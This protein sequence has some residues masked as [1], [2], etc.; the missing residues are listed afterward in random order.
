MTNPS[1]SP[2]K[3]DDLLA[4][5]TDRVLDEKD[6]GFASSTNNELRA[7]E[8]TVLRLQRTLP[9]KSLDKAMLKRMQADF[10]SRSKI[11][12]GSARTSWQSRQ[13]RQRWALAFISLAI[14]VVLFV[15][16]PFSSNGGG[17]LQA[18]AGV[19][20]QSIILILAAAGGTIALFAW[21]RK[22]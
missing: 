19:Q 20:S 22:R 5:F 21:L 2:K 14:L 18:T 9:S 6:S 4:D 12:G 3:M 15:A 10:K 17:G 7:L 8:G 16:T 13:T 11:T 1:P